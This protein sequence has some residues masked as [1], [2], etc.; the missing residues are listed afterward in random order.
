MTRGDEA[1]ALDDH[2]P[3]KTT[4]GRWFWSTAFL[5]GAAVWL[6]ISS[7]L[8]IDRPTLADLLYML[9]MMYAGWHLTRHF[10][11]GV[12]QP[13][14][15]TFRIFTYVWLGLAPIAQSVTGV[16]PRI[17]DINDSAEAAAVIL[18]GMGCW[19]LGRFAARR[20]SAFSGRRFSGVHTGR[21]ALLVLGSFPLAIYYVQSIGG[22]RVAFANRADFADALA[23]SGLV[24]DASKASSAIITAAGQVPIFIGLL[25]MAVYIRRTPRVERFAGA[26]FVLLLLIVG[27]VVVNNPIS[28]SRYW[29]GTILIALLFAV[30]APKRGAYSTV[31]AVGLFIAIAVFP[32]LDYFRNASQFRGQLSGSVFE[33]MSEKDYDAQA[34]I[35]NTISY[36]AA[37]GYTF[38][39]Q[40]LGSAFFWVPRSAWSGKSF[41]TGIV[42]A[43]F[44]NSPNTNLSSPLWAE[45]YIDFGW[46]GVALIFGALGFFVSRLDGI[47]LQ[48]VRAGA[49]TWALIAA[50]VLAGYL[51]IIL[52]GSLLQAA[53]RAAVLALCLLWIRQRRR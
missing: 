17:L 53:G 19:D 49:A 39:D 18:L 10:L 4:V 42:L 37:R 9:I 13:G 52:R 44:I 16:R 1:A 20:A 43:N 26:W 15:L 11:R 6:P 8:M 40:L 34:Q 45:A 35:V 5:L 30:W 46:I 23:S 41:D 32:Y 2:G 3:V 31:V 50:P 48:E 7:Y 24:S 33:V 27:N 25:A 36:V 14:D 28:N 38:G 22:L 21:R 12:P 51:F 29:F 47:Y